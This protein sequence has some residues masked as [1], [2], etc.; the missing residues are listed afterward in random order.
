MLFDTDISFRLNDVDKVWIGDLIGQPDGTNQ[1]N[2]GFFIF[3]NL[4]KNP[5]FKKKFF[6]R[7]MYFIE[8]VFEKNR[9]ESIIRMN[10]N[11]ISLEYDNFYTKWPSVNNRSKW[12]KAI[13]DMIEFNNQRNDIM[14]KIIQNLSDE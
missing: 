6:N 7:Y 9:V 10:K 5:E 3:N 4:I 13:N 2:E 1:S 8:N 14:K 11:N 12:N